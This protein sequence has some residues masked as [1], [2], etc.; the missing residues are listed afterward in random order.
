MGN[1]CLLK[2]CAAFFAAFMLSCSSP[3]EGAITA[4][5]VPEEIREIVLANREVALPQ[6]HPDFLDISLRLLTL[7]LDE[8]EDSRIAAIVAE[9]MAPEITSVD[10]DSRPILPTPLGAISHE[11]AAAEIRLLFDLLRYSYPGYQYF[12]GDEVFAPLRDSMLES[13]TQMMNPLPK[14]QYLHNFLAPSLRTVIA[15][16][17]F[18][19]HNALIG[20]VRHTLF[21]NDSFVIRRGEDGF[22]ADIDGGTYRIIET[23]L[24]D[25]TQVNGILP[26][27]SSEGE[28]VWAFGRVASV[29]ERDA[30]RLFAWIENVET[31]ETRSH[32]LILS[33]ID[34]PRPQSHP[35]LETRMEG[36]VTVLENRSMPGDWDDVDEALAAFAEFHLSGQSMRGTPALIL[37]LRGHRGGIGQMAFEWIRGYADACPEWELAFMPFPLRTSTVGGVALRVRPDLRYRAGP[38]PAVDRALLAG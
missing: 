36:A 10:L 35:S 38:L 25:G 8:E 19:M 23:T 6:F 17:H 31:G 15:D 2:I 9:R 33:R 1:K 16:N 28:L 18:V 7:D 37:D 20:A 3:G 24:L 5:A 27:L 32:N 29:E 14:A 22:E 21:M 30:I 12:G 11:N 13:L 26:S 34:S 4:V